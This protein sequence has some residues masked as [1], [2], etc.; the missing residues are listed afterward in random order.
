MNP[1]SFHTRRKTLALAVVTAGLLQTHSRETVAQQVTIG[2]PMTNV[3]SSFHENIG[4]GW[5]F[6]LPTSNPAVGGRGVVGLGPNGPQQGIGFG[7]GGPAA[8]PFG[9][10]NSNPAN[11]GFQINGGNGGRL[12]FNIFADQGASTTLT[13]QTPMLTVMNG[14]QGFFASTVQRPFVTS[15]I[16]VVS[17]GSVG[18]APTV[19]YPSMSIP[20]PNPSNGNGGASVLNERMTR[21]MANESAHASRRDSPAPTPV[22]APP[23]ARA[24]GRSSAER[25]APSLAEIR[26]AQAAEEVQKDQNLPP[27]QKRLRL[28]E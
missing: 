19:V 25:G 12:G 6:N 17:D 21:I 11:L 10:G 15:L 2:T 20:W 8:V 9:L 13:S 4:V 24:P 26:R 7:F 22:A 3:G 18:Y 14:Q 1:S 27:K 16:P 23:L 5:G 28:E